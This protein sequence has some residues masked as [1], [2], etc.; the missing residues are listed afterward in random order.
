MKLLKTILILLIIVAVFGGAMF[1]LNFYTAPLIEA[2]NAGAELAPL[3][4]VMPEGAQFDGDSLIYSADNA[5]ASTLQNVPAAVLS[6]YKEKNGLGYAIRST[7]IS[8][9]TKSPLE[10]T[11]G[12]TSDGKICGIQIDS[13]GDADGSNWNQKILTND[14]IG[15]YVGQDSALAGVELIANPTSEKAS[16]VAFKNGVAAAL[17]TLIVNDLIT[18]GVKSDAQILEESIIT[19]APGLNQMVEATATGNIQKA[20]KAE[21]GTGFAYIMTEGEATYLAVVNASGVCKVY[22]VDHSAD[23]AA[24]VDVTADHAS[25]VTEAQAHASANQTDYNGAFAT[26]IT[27]VTMMP[28]AT[29]ITPIALDTFNSVVCAVSFTSD[30]ATY[31]G[32][33]SRSIGWSGHAMD[34][35]IIVDENGAIVK[36]DAKEF[37][38]E[39][40]YFATFA[41]MPTDY[42]GGFVG[43]TS[44]TWNDDIAVIATATM[45]SNAMK[46]STKDAF[47]A[48]NSINGGEQ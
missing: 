3:L 32:F 45:T 47:A 4:A 27:N 19:V 9:Y 12:I 21:N 5:A 24:V 31:Y 35:Y 38:F 25:L 41:G 10:V 44:E 1:G 42:K 26:V 30:G 20:L 29:D 36:V 46:Q 6:V 39:E 34:V 7:A 28:N 37:I 43:Q 13:Y 22:G 40:Q 17:E 48:F 14:Y 2:N 33:Y 18:A 8:G 15:T 23:E 11:I 16:S